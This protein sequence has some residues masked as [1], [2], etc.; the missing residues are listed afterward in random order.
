VTTYQANKTGPRFWKIV[1]RTFLAGL[2]LL[3]IAYGGDYGQFR[4]RLAAQRHPFGRVTVQHY[5]SVAH[6]DGKTELFFDP[7]VQA[8]CAHSVFPHSGVLP[9]WFLTRHAEPKTDI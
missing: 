2:I 3:A 7:P 8:T 1:W 9:C 5:Y 6:K 4:Y